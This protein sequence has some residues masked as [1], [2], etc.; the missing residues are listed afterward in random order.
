MAEFIDNRNSLE[1]EVA[2]Y[3]RALELNPN[4]PGIRQKLADALYQQAKAEQQTLLQS[5]RQ[6]LRRN[7]DDIPTYRKALELQPDDTELHLE[8]GNALARQGLVNEA[9]QAYRRVLQLQPDRTEVAQK[10]ETLLKQREKNSP[11]KPSLEQAKRVL[12]T[13]NRTALEAFLNSGSR[14][15]FP[16]V[17]Y[18]EISIILV[19]YN[20]ADLTLSCLESIAQNSFKSIELLIVDNAST[21]E[22]AQLLERIE[23]AKIIRNSDNLHYL[24]GCNQAT[25]E[26]TGKYLLF[27]NNDTRI[28]GDSLTAA[29]ATLQSD[30]NIGAVGGKIIFPDGTLQEAGSLIWR[31][32][33]CCCYGRGDSP[34]AYPY[35]FRRVVD[36]CCGAFLL[37]PRDLFVELGGFDE[38]FQPAYYEETDYCVRLQQRGK[39]IV[40]EPNINVIHYEFA[41][42]DRDR[43]FELMA[44]NQKIFAAKHR[45]WLQQKPPAN[46]GNILPYRTASND[47]KRL[48]MIDDRVPHR[49]S[50][51]GYTRSHSILAQIVKLGYSVTLYPVDTSVRENWTDIY[52]DI[53][54]DVEVAIDR[55]IPKL[56]EFLRERAGYY[57]IIFVSRP[58]NLEQLDRL[59]RQ[60]R[61]PPTPRII[62]DSEAIFYLRDLEKQRSQGKEPS[63]EAIKTAKEKELKPAQICDRIIAVSPAERQEF[64]NYG[65]SDVRLLGHSLTPSPTPNEFGDRQHFLFVGA[66]YELD[67][68]NA[69]SILWLARDIFKH[70]KNRLENDIELKI[71]GINTVEALTKQMKTFDIPSIKILGKVDNLAALYNQCRVFVAPTRFAAGI[72]HKVHEAAAHGLPVV[73]TSLIAKQLGWEP[74]ID[75]LVADNSEDFA[76]QCDRL[77]TDSELW[78]LIRR[79]AL[80]RIKTD[81]S[82]EQFTRTLAE[83]LSDRS[84]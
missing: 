63:P 73:T 14:L 13:L 24:R 5:Y 74:E 11:D 43:A 18:P 3:Q 81:C 70:I 82:P 49:I 33:S 21:D 17:E 41:S 16:P 10:L 29:I 1:D 39:Q 34:T 48:L 12:D 42:S 64:I 62:Y 26:A 84:V 53:P 65:Y 79:N 6:K 30:S 37:T 28:L 8:L 15:H 2:T 4:L 52:S 7:P 46:L 20:R 57:D 36:Y 32:G 19:L 25:R 45:D 44:K 61:R 23:G 31:D 22:T 51:S 59:L 69:D 58:N 71:A 75:L 72:P 76:T 66:I 47:G 83:I 27:L 80:D 40:Y 50:G 35:M 55:G 78:S 9:G 68:P 60:N 67:S 77:Y 38:A 54:R 56:E